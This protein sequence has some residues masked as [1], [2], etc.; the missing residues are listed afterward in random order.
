MKSRP[1]L[2]ARSLST[3]GL[4]GS[5][6]DTPKVSTHGVRRASSGAG[7]SPATSSSRHAGAPASVACGAV[8]A[9]ALSCQRAVK[10]V[11]P[12]CRS[13]GRKRPPNDGCGQS[14]ASVTRVLSPTGANASSPVPTSSR[15]TSARIGRRAPANDSA[16][17]A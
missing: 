10:P 16:T 17:S 4:T 9:R 14:D 5:M 11:P 3:Y 15:P 6:N 13:I 8:V 1:Y 7:A 12:T 2:V